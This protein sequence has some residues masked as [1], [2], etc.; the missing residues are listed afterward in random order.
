M[1][2]YRW[3]LLPTVAVIVVLVAL[4]VASLDDDLVYYLTPS[5][6]AEQRVDFAD[7][8]RFRLGG[9]VLSGSVSTT[10]DGVRFDV[11]DGATVVRVEHRGTPPQLFQ[12]DIGVVVEG[13]WA[14][15]VFRSD[16]LMVRH[17]EQYRAPDGDG[18]YEPPPVDPAE[19]QR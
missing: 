1:R 9:L 3:F 7:G 6:A 16:L 8:D 12:E 2:S 13:A 10:G 19:A 15:D 11:G 4:L 5:E 14:G 18:P 17:D